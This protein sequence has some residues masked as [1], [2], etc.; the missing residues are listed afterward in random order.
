MPK[1]EKFQ[2]DLDYPDYS[3]RVSVGIMTFE[4]F[5]GKKNIGSSRIRGHWVAE[6][7]GDAEEMI[8]GKKYDTVIY[9]KA[10]MV[11]HAQVFNGVKILDLCDPDWLDWGYRTKEMIEVVDGI[12]TS[13]QALADA[14]SNFT[15]KPVKF[16]RDRMKISDHKVKK[17]HEGIAEK[18]VWFGYSHNFPMLKS[19]LAPIAKN[20]LGLIVISDSA[21]T[22]PAPY[23]G[24]IDLINYPWNPETIHSDI[25]K[26]DIALNPQSSH[27]KWRF[28]SENKTITAN[29]LGIPVAEDPTD[30]KRLMSEDERKK[31]A[32]QDYQ[33]A[34]KNYDVKISVQEYKDFIQEIKD[35]RS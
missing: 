8:V 20:N 29:L 34:V 32:E 22:L 23:V 19:A 25:I 5:H 13:T 12:S 11:D 27:G 28:K 1:K 4:K 30:L 9:Q 24:R 17:V 3:K 21:F 35:L 33:N 16:I 7:W 14:V 31:Q 18:V 10:Y 26:A 6:E 15:D 2:V